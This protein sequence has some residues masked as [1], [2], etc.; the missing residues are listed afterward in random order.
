MNYTKALGRV[1]HKMSHICIVLQLNMACGK[2]Y[3]WLHWRIHSGKARFFVDSHPPTQN[4][5][6]EKPRSRLHK[7]LNKS[8]ASRKHLRE[9]VKASKGDGWSC[10]RNSRSRNCRELENGRNTK[11]L[12]TWRNHLRKRKIGGFH[13][14]QIRKKPISWIL[15]R[16]KLDAEHANLG[17]GRIRRFQ[18]G[19]LIFKR[20][21]SKGVTADKFLSWIESSLG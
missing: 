6:E 13:H 1:P 18:E 14:L 8:A 21:K 15:G 20:K 11:D 19:H 9:K 12:E 16:V 10:W 4:L 5:G 2:E 17:D 3:N 7:W